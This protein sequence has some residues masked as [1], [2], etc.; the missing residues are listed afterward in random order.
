MNLP[1]LALSV[2]LYAFAC[3]P[4]WRGRGIMKQVYTVLFEEA[5]RQAPAVCLVPASDSLM[6]AYNRTGRTF[7]PLGRIRSARVTGAG[8]AGALPAERLTWQEYARR[9]EKWLEPYP[10]AVY[11]ESF[12]ALSAEY[13][14]VYLSLPGALAAVSSQAD[15]MLV[16]ELLCPSADP[17]RA[18]AGIAA[19]CPAGQYEVR[20]PLFFPGSGEARRF[21]YIHGTAEQ[22][23]EPET[24][25][26]PFGLE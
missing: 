12:Y 22:A 1:F 10:H 6:Q 9:R 26:Y 16:N 3:L 24:F 25:W 19:V 21:A 2:Y 13:G 14:Y 15:R 17:E 18:L 11:P 5:R 20:T 7:V 23:E 4:A 8:P